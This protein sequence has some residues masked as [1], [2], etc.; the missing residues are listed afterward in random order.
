[1]SAVLEG[2]RPIEPDPTS[3]D[4]LVAPHRSA[5]LAHCYRMTGSVHDAED[6]V[7]ETMLRAWRSLDGFEGRS[8]LRTWLHT[9]A[10]NS[11][12]RL[13]EQRARRVLPIDLGPATTPGDA[14]G[15]PLAESLW[16]TPFAAPAADGSPPA[17]YEDKETVELAFVAAMQLLPARQRAVLLLR[18][19]VGFSAAE[20]AAALDSTVASVNSAL[21]RARR[22]LEQSLPRRSQQQ[23]L[24]AL[25]DAEAKALV[26]RFVR[27]WEQGDVEALVAVLAE[28]VEFSMPPYA[29]WFRGTADVADFVQREP[30]SR[31]RRWRGRPIEVNGQLGVAFW[32]VTPAG[33][34]PESVAVLSVTG[35]RISAVTAFRSP[36]LFTA[37]GLPPAPA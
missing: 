24:R 1:M 32:L 33:P 22:A 11:C 31:G 21:Q 2:S 29:Q 16:I 37:L 14:S 12:R 6:A 19:V 26:G 9:I 34:E 3:F 25:G 27:A 23:T 36:G 10:T 30:W 35:T 5:L 4:Q 17:R 18:D 8:S 28:D 15:P 13:L 20:T 7:Q